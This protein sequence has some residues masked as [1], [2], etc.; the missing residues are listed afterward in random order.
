MVNNIF[1]SM[2]EQ[3]KT[4]YEPALKFNQLVLSNTEKFARAQMK[5]FQ[6]Y[7]ELGLSQ[8]HDAANLKEAGDFKDFINKQTEFAGSISKKMS[9]DA[10]TLVALSNEF[11][12]DITKFAEENA[13]D[14]NVD[15][16]K[17]KTHA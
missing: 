1:N 15:S 13:K 3:A 9:D 2:G 7:A 11:K 6:E 17:P 12:D 10:N 5:L 14:F 4:M 8:L 16:F